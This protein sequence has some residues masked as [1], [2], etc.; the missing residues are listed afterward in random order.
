MTALLSILL[1]PRVLLGIAAAAVLAFAGLKLYH[2]GQASTQVEFDAWKLA[3]A[4]NRMLADRAQRAEEQRRQEVVNQEAKD[5]A[6]KLTQA[7]ADGVAAAAARDSM[8][9][10]LSTFLAAVHRAGQDPAPPA[11]GSR[12][13]GPD[14]LDLLA[15]LYS[16]A[17][18]EAGVLAGYADELRIRGASCERI[19]DRL[20]PPAGQ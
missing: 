3:A 12:V 14:P 15:D 11:G 4:E 1:N 5:A 10:Q 7:R 18:D 17:D 20:Q 19:T 8:R 6:Q 9:D 16:R 2:A 13:R